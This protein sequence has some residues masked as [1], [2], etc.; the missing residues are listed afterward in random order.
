MPKSTTSPGGSGAPLL[1]SGEQLAQQLHGRFSE[2]LRIARLLQSW[3]QSDL[4]RYTW[5]E[6]TGAG[7]KRRGLVS[8]YEGGR[9][10]PSETNLVA[11]AAV[12]KIEPDQLAPDL[13]ASRRITER[14][15]TWINDR[16]PKMD[17]RALKGGQS[18]LHIYT[19]V[20][21]AVALEIQKLIVEH[22]LGATAFAETVEE[23]LTTNGH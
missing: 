13:A 1:V 12:F 11:L 14:S 4:A 7:A 6:G 16:E 8:L 15:R 3:S 2:R 23:Y 20:P 17:S 22:Q 9:S 19:I 5:G 21:S 10:L 18:L